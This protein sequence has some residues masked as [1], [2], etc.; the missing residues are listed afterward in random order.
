MATGTGFSGGFAP[1]M[2]NAVPSSLVEISVECRYKID[3]NDM[4]IVIPNHFFCPTV[5][6]LK[7]LNMNR[8]RP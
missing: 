7:T 8:N 4:L 3:E 5:K 2:G 1:G 6:S